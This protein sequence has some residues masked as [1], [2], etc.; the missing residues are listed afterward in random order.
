MPTMALMNQYARRIP[1]IANNPMKI[2]VGILSISFNANKTIDG[3]K[4]IINPPFSGKT[5]T[6]NKIIPK[7]KKVR[8]A[9]GLGF[10]STI[11]FDF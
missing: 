2:L 10:S 1:I 9:T 3:M 8:L 4:Q 6:T 5:S 11:F 7:A